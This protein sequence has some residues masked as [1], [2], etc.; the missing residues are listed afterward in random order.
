MSEIAGYANDPTQPDISCCKYRHL[1]QFSGK[2][3]QRTL[4]GLLRMKKPILAAVVV[5]I[6]ELWSF[7]QRVEPVPAPADVALQLG[8]EG[9]EH[10]FHLG[11]LIPIRFSYRADNP[12]RYI[13][14]G[15][16]T[17]LAG[18]HSLEIACSPTAERVKR[19][20]TAP[21][22]IAFGQI[23]NAD[24]GG[25]GFGGGIG[26]GCGDCDGELPLTTAALTFGIVPLNTYVRFRTP[27]IYTCQGSSAEIT[28][29][30]RDEKIRPALLVKSNSITVTIVDDPAWAHPAATEYADTYDKL[31]RADDVAEH[32]SSQC[33]DVA[34]RI[35]YL[36]TAESLAIEV[37]GID[38]RNHGWENGFWDAIRQSS[39]PREA[40]HMMTS[41]IQEP[42]FKVSPSVLEWLASLELRIE[43]PDAFQGGMPANYRALAV[44]KLRKYVRL[45]GNSLSRKN[46]DVLPESAKAYRTF[47]EQKY[48]ERE[49]LISMEERSQVLAAIAHRP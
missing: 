45:L 10:Q 40:L 49:S 5:F 4:I 43:V 47:A 25:V 9:G 11:E 46:S 42:D 44:E 33:F 37:R 32:R 29:S 19:Y 23:L 30:S 15:N 7:T 8:T 31:C 41:R 16:G 2:L 3:V 26:G 18:G 14:A 48:C 12:G 36:D 21:D 20:S 28:A 6:L 35:T 1:R 22:D 39:H 17:K 13:W 27:G 38:G 24:C 34:E